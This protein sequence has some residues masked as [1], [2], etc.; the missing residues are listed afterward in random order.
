M[1]VPTGTLKTYEAI[2]NREDLANMIYDI[3]PTQT[4]LMNNIGR[5]KCSSTKT[6]WQTDVLEAATTANKVLE[7]DDAST[8]TATPT[9]RL[10]NIC[11]ISDKVPRV[12]GT[13]ESMDSAGRRSEMSYQVAKRGKELKRDIEKTLGG[14]QAGDDASAATARACAGLGTFM[15]TNQKKL[16]VGTTASVVTM[17][18]GFPN[19]A[20]V[21]GTPGTLVEANLKD[22]ISNCWDEGGEP[23]MV[24]CGSHNKQL[25]SGFSG[26]ATQYRDNPQTGPGTIIGAADV[27][28]SDFGT[29]SIVPSRYVPTKVVYVIDPGSMEACYLRPISMHDLAKTGDSIRKQ[30]LAE[31]TLKVNSPSSNS[32]IHTTTTS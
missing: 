10:A 26:I 12:S 18:S 23:S 7:G 11:Q 32:M 9:V 2:G 16:G 28:V 27:Y 20:V 8:N 5:G 17:T 19:T 29:V 15:W 1:A 30:L 6:E 22:A 25:I 31:Y 3:S 24:L 4:P 13:Q 14:L 21:D